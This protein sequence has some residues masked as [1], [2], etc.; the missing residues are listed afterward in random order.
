M[1]EASDQEKALDAL[2]TL[3]RKG[4]KYVVLEFSGGHDEGSIQHAE[5]Y[6]PLKRDAPEAPSDP[7]QALRTVGQRHHTVDVGHHELWTLVAP[8]E[9]P[10][11]QVYGSFAGE[12]SIYGHVTWDVAERCAVLNSE[13]TIWEEQPAWVFTPT[14]QQRTE[15]F[16]AAD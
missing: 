13:E 4:I 11:Y 16:A 7:D 3:A 10:V 1:S 14:D 5:M 6:G 12:C 9:Y 2:D 8:L 15:S